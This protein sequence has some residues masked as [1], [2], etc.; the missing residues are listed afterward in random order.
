MPSE[1]KPLIVIVEDE[2]ALAQMISEQL[3]HAGMLTQIFN[4]AANV[5]RF[6]QNNHVN[7]AL[8]DI[9]LPDKSGFELFTDMQKADVKVPAVYL[10]GNDSEV[11]KVK[12]LEMGGDDYIL[13]PFSFPELIARIHAVLRRTEQAHD[14]NVTENASI[15]DTEFEFAGAMICPNHMEVTFPNDKKEKLGKKE[16]GIMAYLASHPDTVLTRRSLIHAV[17]GIHADVRSRSLDQYI[18]KIRDMY[19]RN[20]SQ[21]DTLRTIHGV[22]YTYESGK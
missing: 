20:D 15:T 14:Y 19:S 4:S 22:G 3:E 12:G 10:T 18:V 2:K 16:L 7:L 17:W 1:S 9:T 8:L 6:M 21:L 11:D 5:V 13:K